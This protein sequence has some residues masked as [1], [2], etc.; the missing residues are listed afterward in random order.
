M[1]WARGEL[2]ERWRPDKPDLELLAERHPS[3][4][5]GGPLYCQYRHGLVAAGREQVPVAKNL[6]KA[7]A[8]LL[9]LIAGG[10]AR[11]DDSIGRRTRDATPA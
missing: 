5:R 9:F 8:E 1:S 6:A 10:Q 7:E 11:A 2:V 3:G 4:V